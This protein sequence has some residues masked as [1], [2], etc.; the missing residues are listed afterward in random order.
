MTNSTFSTKDFGPNAGYVEEL[1]NLYESGS[2]LVDSSWRKLFGGDIKEN[3]GGGFSRESLLAQLQVFQLISAYRKA[4]HLAATTNPLSFGSLKPEIPADLVFEN[5]KFEDAQLNQNFFSGGLTSETDSTPAKILAQLQHCYCGNVGFEFE[6][7]ADKRIRD[8]MIAAIEKDYAKKNWFSKDVKLRYLHRLIE[9]ESFDSF[10]HTRFIGSKR[11][12]IAGAESFVVLLQR[13][14]DSSAKLGVE[15]ITLS[16]AHRGRMNAVVTFA[17]K[18]HSELAAEFEDRA[19]ASISGGG[20]VKYHLGSSVIH[21]VD[22]RDVRFSIPPNPSHLEFVNSV[23]SGMVRAKQD[24]TYAANPSA[25]L[26][27]SVHGDASFAGQGIVAELFNLAGLP[28]YDS[29]GTIH[30]II[31]NQVGFTTSSSEAR[32]STYCSDMAKGFNVPVFHVNSDD[33]DACAWV[34]DAALRFRQEF[35]R[36]V[37]IDLICSRKFG[38][39]E[40]DDPTFTQPLLYRELSA[41]QSV[42]AYYSQRLVSEA[43]STQQEVDK[44]KAETIAS[45]KAQFEDPKPPLLEKYDFSIQE[46]NSTSVESARLELISDSLLPKSPEFNLHPKLKGILEKR[47]NALHVAHGIDWGLAEA[48]AFGSLLL[49]GISVRLSGQDAGRGTFSHRHLEIH[50][51]KNGMRT[52][53]LEE[54]ARGAGTRAKFRVFNS[55]L[56]E[57][58]VMGFDFGYAAEDPQTLVLWEGQFGDFANGAQVIIDQFLASSEQKWNQRSGLVLLLPHGFEGQGPEHSSARLERFLQLCSNNNMTVAFPTSPAQY[59]HLLR[60][61]AMSGSKR[62]LVVMTPKSMLRLAE[63]GSSLEDL[64]AGRF[65]KIIVSGNSKDKKQPV[66]LCSGKVFYPVRKA[67]GDSVKIIRIEQLYPWPE[68]EIKAALGSSKQAF[69]VQEEPENMGAAR[70]VEPLLRKLGVS[71]TYFGREAAAG[72]ATGSPSWHQKEEKEFLSSLLEALK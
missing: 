8:W 71:T 45:L 58:A 69:W 6:H 24:S 49:D 1:L 34:A 55:P 56:S 26:S 60:R 62:P 20:D 59:F 31:N 37:V 5:Y 42:A 54:L 51:N 30:I 46:N 63:A 50:D 52:Y 36:D 70:Y 3:G 7:I 66:V 38:H 65:E 32:S 28:G 35:K 19:S 11:F 15:D 57:A 4:G 2:P 67:L 22:G 47:H 12:S 61:Q 33:V 27:L 41:R 64:S 14:I 16:M 68:S 10:L 43:V 29:A 17:G 44:L 53:P 21:K 23:A 13:I 48:L 18:P 40:G 39:N 72:V 25:A 9:A